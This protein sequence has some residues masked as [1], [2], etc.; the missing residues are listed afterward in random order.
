MTHNASDSKP[1]PPYD[2]RNMSEAKTEPAVSVPR[3]V[4]YRVYCPDGAIPANTAFDP[5][6][7]YLGRI[8]ARS[9]PPPHNV[10]TLK[11]CLIKA[12]KL[13]DADGSR[14][15]LYRAPDAP[16][17]L[18][19]ADKVVIVGPGV[20]NG[21][22]PDSALALV[23]LSDLTSDE[24]AAIARMDLSRRHEEEEPKYLYY[25]LFTPTGEDNS[26]MSFNSSEPAVG[27]VERIFVSPPSLHYDYQTPHC[28]TQE[29][30][31][32][33]IHLTLME[34]S[35]VGLT[36][37]DPIVLVQ[38]ER[39]RGLYNRPVNVV[40]DWNQYFPRGSLAY[41]DAVLAYNKYKCV[42]VLNTMPSG[43]LHDTA[44]LSADE[45]QF[46]DE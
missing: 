5:R 17:N 8:P 26:K 46:L 6:T 35:T 33:Y 18:G 24:S 36:E 41:T 11:R 43:S 19:A 32:D 37:E 21:A 29:T 30:I 15:V 42:R 7:P 2:A 22:T 12:E 16:N 14:T 39:R 20:E 9:V 4:Y 28:E 44:H 3:Y 45:I 38:P 27:R 34:N 23:L 10:V 1:P 13:D 31:A 40:G 25:R